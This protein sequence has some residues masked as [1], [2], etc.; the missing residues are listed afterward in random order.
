MKT[1]I[2]LPTDN[3]KI[4]SNFL[5]FS[6]VYIILFAFS[7]LLL[8]KLQNAFAYMLVTQRRTLLRIRI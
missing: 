8:K 5:E 4:F 1:L 3:L 2:I 7:A 6:Y